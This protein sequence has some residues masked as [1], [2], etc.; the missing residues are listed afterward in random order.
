[1]WD[2][3]YFILILGDVAHGETPDCV[4]ESRMSDVTY[5]EGVRGDILLDDD[6]INRCL[7]LAVHLGV[8][9]LEIECA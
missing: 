9:T 5:L 4:I 1:M 3:F 8:I 7:I 6:S 2:Y